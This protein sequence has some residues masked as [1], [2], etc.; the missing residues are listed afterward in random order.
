MLALQQD[1]EIHRL[2]G[3]V[4]CYWAFGRNDTHVLDVNMS[5]IHPFESRRGCKDP[6]L[7][8][9]WKDLDFHWSSLHQIVGR[10]HFVSAVGIPTRIRSYGS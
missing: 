3:P 5:R 10:K 4:V 8:E 1:G 9:P 2:S 6:L 7:R